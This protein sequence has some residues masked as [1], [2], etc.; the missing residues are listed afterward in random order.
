MEIE[1]AATVIIAVTGSTGNDLKYASLFLQF[2]RSS[3]DT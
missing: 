3:C 2:Y 1:F